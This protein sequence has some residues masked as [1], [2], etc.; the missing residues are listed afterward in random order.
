[1]FD[2]MDEIQGAKSTHAKEPLDELDRYLKADIEPD[3]K[4]P[5]AYWSDSKNLFP[6]LSQMGLDYHAIPR[7]SSLD[8]SKCAPYLL[9]FTQQ[10]RLRWNAFSAVDDFS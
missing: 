10:R 6:R 7:T 8:R 4:D 1:M 2:H 3:V 9:K 5:I